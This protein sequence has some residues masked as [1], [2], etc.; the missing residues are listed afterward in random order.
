MVVIVSEAT[1]P[2]VSKGAAIVASDGAARDGHVCTTA[3]V[4]VGKPACGGGGNCCE[5]G[6]ESSCFQE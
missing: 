4:L 1:V 6:L 5:R 3:D 2:T